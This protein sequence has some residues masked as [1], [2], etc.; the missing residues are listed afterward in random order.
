MFPILLLRDGGAAGVM[1]RA[2]LIAAACA[3]CGLSLATS[4]EAQSG[5]TMAHVNRAVRAVAE[6]QK[7]HTLQP[8]QRAVTELEGVTVTHRRGTERDKVT[9]TWFAVFR[10]LDHAK[11]ASFNPSDLPEASIVPPAVNGVRY[12]S[13]TDARSISD[14]EARAQYEQLVRENRAKSQRFTLQYGLRGL[15]DRATNAF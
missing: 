9:R 2:T 4:S 12:P 8:L 13:G 5:A 10:A 11:D 15:D 3:A 7:G 14:P 1:Y 6:F